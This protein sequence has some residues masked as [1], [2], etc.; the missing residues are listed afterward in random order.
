LRDDHVLYNDPKKRTIRPGGP[1]RPA[2]PFLQPLA[3]ALISLVLV[4]LALV[5]GLMDLGTLDKTLSGYIEKRG[6][7]IIKNVQQ[8]ARY[9]FHLLGHG[10]DSD[11]EGLAGSGLIEETFSLREAMILDLLGLA[12]R[13]DFEREQGLLDDPLLTSL[14]VGQGIWLVALLDAQGEITYRNRPVPKALLESAVRVITGDDGI[15]V[16]LFRPSTDVTRTRSFAI[17]RKRGKGSILFAL[18]QADFLFWRARVSIEQ[19]VMEVGLGTDA[20]Y[21]VV[22]DTDGRI[23][24]QTQEVRASAK[25]PDQASDREGGRTIDVIFPLHLNGEPALNAW[26][27][28]S[29]ETADHMLQK[30]RQRG[31]IFIGFMVCIAILSMGFL[32]RSQARHL[33]NMREMERRL[34]RAERLSAMGRLAAG[35]AHEIRNPLNA[36]SMACQRLQ[37]DNLNQLSKVIRDEILLLNHI[38]E[39]FISFPRCG[40]P[41]L[42]EDDMTALVRQM[43]LLVEEE[44]SS[45]GIALRTDWPESPLMIWM[46]ADKIRQALFN[47]I[48]NAMES[49]PDRGTI[50]LALSQEGRRWVAIRISDTGTGLSPEEVEQIFDPDYTTKEKGLGLGLAL[51]HEIIAAH[52]GEIRVKSEP[53]T[54]TAFEVVLPVGGARHKA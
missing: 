11:M 23:L 2:R 19:A 24:F 31:F 18:N 8:V 4:S 48:K 41:V 53:G 52:G 45:R 13:I 46:D 1:G 54:G 22:T 50:T 38:V 3:V 21:F 26:L 43:A 42:K 5:T 35:V 20:R 39:E 9:N 7:D 49:I 47:I 36:M 44:T 25:S 33:A 15:M 30:E 17:R 37:K 29:R 27:A 34:H 51:A 14:A 40:N 28:L 32:Y 10:S 16:E 12:Q 6:L